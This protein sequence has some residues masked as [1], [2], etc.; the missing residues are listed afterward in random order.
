MDINDIAQRAIRYFIEGAAVAL[1]AFYIPQKKMDMRELLMI[2]VTAAATFAVLDTFAPEIG[3]GARKGTGFGIGANVAG[4]N[5]AKL[6]G[7]NPFAG[8]PYG[9]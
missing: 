6:V 4:W 7:G 3:M 5:V 1:V 8:N 2:A 9:F